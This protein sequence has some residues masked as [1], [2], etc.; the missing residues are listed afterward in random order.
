MHQ[1]WSATE[2]EAGVMETPEVRSGV[3]QADVLQ[4]M[5]D[6]AILNVDQPEQGRTM[7]IVLVWLGEQG[8]RSRRRSNKEWENAA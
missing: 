4:P 2:S 6:M 7:D 5:R 8:C 3:L 1:K